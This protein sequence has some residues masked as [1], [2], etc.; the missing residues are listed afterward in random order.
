MASNISNIDSR[1]PLDAVSVVQR[2]KVILVFRVNTRAFQMAVQG[3]KHLE[4]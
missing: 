2:F 1:P 4:I 3:K